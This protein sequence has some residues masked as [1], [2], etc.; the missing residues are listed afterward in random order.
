MIKKVRLLLA[1]VSHL[2][3]IQIKYQ[4]I[5]RLKKPGTL[6]KYCES[7][8]VKIDQPL[9]FRIM[10]P[11]YKSFLEG[12]IFVFLN[13]TVDFGKEIDWNFQGNGKLWNYNLQYGNFL[14]QEEV[15][16]AA[17]VRLIKSIYSWLKDGR[18]NLEPYPASL[19]I[20]NIIRFVTQEN[21]LDQDILVSLRGELSYLSVHPEYHIMGNHLLENGFSLI[22][23]GAFFN[24]IEWLTQGRQIIE[25]ELNEQILNDGAHFELSPMYHQIIFFR[26]LELIDWYSEYEKVDK[27]FL[28][29][30]KDKAALML[31]W[32]KVI[33]FRNGDI[34]HLNDSSDCISYSTDWLAQYSAMLNVEQD[35]SV[36]I[37][38]S[39]YRTFSNNDYECVI[40]LAQIGPS[41][42][43][44]HGHSDALSFILYA[45]SKP[46]FVE[47]GTSTYQIGARRNTERSTS[48]HNTVEVNYMNQSNVWS[49][50][51][52]G[53]RAN[54]KILNETGSKFAGT[55]DGYKA[56]G[57]LHKR[58]FDF[59]LSKIEIVDELIGKTAVNSIAYFHLHPDLIIQRQDNSVIIDGI[60]LIT[61]DGNVKVSIENYEMAN[62]F[63]SYLT[64]KRILV[65]FDRKLISNIILSK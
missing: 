42:Q 26:L 6:L 35:Q 49:G 38:E 46:V 34:P 44:G 5:Y 17:K 12:N 53:N 56:I 11:V 15:T 39:G 64:G 30:L 29:F 47:Q 9:S 27:G 55:Q 45:N 54:V 41:Y 23:G 18:L 32:L 7:S 4:I 21:I 19:R 10:P 20:I 59:Q 48:A 51:R 25:S 13:Q 14:L 2:K 58:A 62:G 50:F 24:N 16:V 31:S 37:K 33:T 22:V 65:N 52:V 60:G 61:F 43:A 28:S 8:V 1:T 3:W 57:L 63:N 40:D 36:S